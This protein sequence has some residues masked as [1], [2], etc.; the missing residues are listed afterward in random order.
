[1]ETK[2]YIDNL[3]A[4]GLSTDYL[5]ALS[6][7]L[8]GSTVT[9]IGEEG[10]KIAKIQEN[11]KPDK[12][13]YA[14]E[15]R[16][17][18]DYTAFEVFPT[19]IEIPAGTYDCNIETLNV[20]PEATKANYEKY[21]NTVVKVEGVKYRLNTTP[22]NGYEWEQTTD[23]TIAELFGHNFDVV[24]GIQYKNAVPAKSIAGF[25]TKTYVDQK[26]NDIVI[27][28]GDGTKSVVKDL[29]PETGLVGYEDV[30]TQE[31]RDDRKV[32]VKHEYSSDKCNQR[33]IVKIYG[34]TY[35]TLRTHCSGATSICSRI[36]EYDLPISKTILAVSHACSNSDRLLRLIISEY[37]NF[38]S[39]MNFAYA[40]QN[41]ANLV[42]IHM[43]DKS[44]YYNIMKISSQFMFANCKSLET[45]NLRIP[46]NFYN[47]NAFIAI[48]FYEGC[49]NLKVDI[50]NLLPLNGF[51]GRVVSLENC[52]KGCSMLT[53]SITKTKV[54][55]D[56]SG[57]YYTLDKILW[58]DETKL[59]FTRRCFN[60]CTSLDDYDSIPENWIK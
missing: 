14:P 11:G 43:S 12:Y 42:K 10:V 7:N 38:K 39:A 54:Q 41:A 55:P 32:Q 19:N 15:S 21:L 47:G 49:S 17:E 59:W 58:N 24:T 13:I 16:N 31:V 6:S 26:D 35:T 57:S 5:Y 18:V 48:S 50:K 20:L 1:M 30:E 52:F 37:Y 29:T 9:P 51:S 60:G 36:F 22:S 4:V 33:Y 27:D 46:N 8:T 44:N 45:S 53:G 40:F 2:L 56:W 28:W 3:S 23:T 25:T 34:T